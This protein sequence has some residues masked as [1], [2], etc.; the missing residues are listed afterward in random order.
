MAALFGLLCVLGICAV[1]AALDACLGID[2]IATLAASGAATAAGLPKNGQ[3]Q[4]GTAT[5]ENA[6]SNPPN[7]FVD[8]VSAEITELHKEDIA[9]L[10]ILESASRTKLNVTNGDFARVHRYYQIGERPD[11]CLTTADFTAGAGTSATLQLA[12]DT[13][14][15]WTRDSIIIPCKPTAAGGYEFIEGW[16]YNAPN[17]S[18]VQKGYLQL[19]VTAVDKSAGTITVV[20][21]NGERTIASNA[22][23]SKVPSL[24]AGTLLMRMDGVAAEGDAMADSYL[25]MPADTHNYVQISHSAKK[26]TK[27][28]MRRAKEVNF[29]DAQISEQILKG[30][31][32]DIEKDLLFG[33][34]AHYYD[35]VKSK[36]VY[37]AG[38]FLYFNTNIYEY[39]VNAAG[40]GLTLDDLSAL[41][42]QLFHGNNGS[43]TRIMLMGGD[44][45]ERINKALQNNTVIQQQQQGNLVISAEVEYGLKFK[46]IN[47]MFGKL[48]ARLYYM[49]DRMNM[50][51]CA[52]CIDPRHLALIDVYGYKIAERKGIE[53]AGL[54]EVDASYLTR[55]WTLEVRNPVTHMLI[56][57]RLV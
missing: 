21:T 41:S 47:N 17:P 42:K 39:A 43:Q 9:L 31:M 50:S 36:M 16:D 1:C 56:R 53:A 34:M 32:L 54:E 19:A 11:G 57:P 27:E 7:L 18:G 30:M 23:T 46:G 5:A 3:G 15:M 6:E 4:S 44:F 35:P 20:A 12:A 14:L 49:L 22:Q 26:V 2:F 13:V 38:G 52:I 37:K 33:Q 8:S 51:D 10:W 29:G 45:A 40:E 48:N 24:P 25:E 55:A 28:F